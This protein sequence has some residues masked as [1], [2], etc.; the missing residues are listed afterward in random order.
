MNIF[1]TFLFLMAKNAK[2]LNVLSY[3]QQLSIFWHILKEYHAT[4]KILN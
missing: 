4:I 2:K 3:R 1:I